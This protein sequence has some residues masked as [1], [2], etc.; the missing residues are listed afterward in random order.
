MGVTF[1]QRIAETD[2]DGKMKVKYLAKDS[3]GNVETRTQVLEDTILKSVSEQVQEGLSDGSISVSGASI[4]SKVENISDQ[5]V[6]NK[7]IYNIPTSAIISSINVF[8]NG[9]SV[10]DDMISVSDTQFEFDSTKYQSDDFSSGVLI[11]S[12]IEQ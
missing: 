10:I 5:L 1:F 2:T 11:V 6:F 9:V 12:Y 7:Y 4:S 3:S 8:F